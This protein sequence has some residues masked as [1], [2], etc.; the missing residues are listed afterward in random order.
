MTR[1]L[2]AVN[3]FSGEECPWIGNYVMME[4]GTGAVMS[5]PAQTSAISSLREIRFAV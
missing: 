5:V 4:Y 1:D 3:P 2:K